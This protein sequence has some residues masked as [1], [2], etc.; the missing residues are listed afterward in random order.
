MPVRCA[1]KR[2][3]TVETST[4]GSEMVATRIAT[5]LIM[6]YRYN[7]WMLGVPVEGPVMLLGD[8]LSVILNATVPSS[9]LKK[10]HLA[11]IYHQVREAVAA[12]IMMFCHIN[13]KDNVSNI[14]TKPLPLVQHMVPAKKLVFCRPVD[15][16]G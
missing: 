9:M 11:C 10:K 12:K 5:E 13:S 15:F 14:L 4:Y 3:K 1:S 7:L 16:S 6:E 2:Q 8:N